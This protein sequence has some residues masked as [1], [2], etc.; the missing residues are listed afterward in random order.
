MAYTIY[1]KG[2]SL[3]KANSAPGR[4]NILYLGHISG[5]AVHDAVFSGISR[6]A[7]MRGWTAESV[8]YRVAHGK[9]LSVIL[10]EKRPV[11]CIVECSNGPPDLPPAAF[12]RVPAVFMNC[13]SVP[14]GRRIA[15][16]AVDN[17]SVAAAA[18]RELSSGNP[19]GF[20]AVGLSDSAM[21][22]G[23]WSNARV[24]AFRA[25][26]R[27]ERRRCLCLVDWGRGGDE[28]DA[29]LREWIAEL[30]PRTAV[31]AVNDATA[32]SIARAAKAAGRSI[33]R[34]LTLVGVDNDSALCETVSPSLSSIPMDF[35]SGGFLAARLLGEMM[36]AKKAAEQSLATKDTKKEKDI[37]NS[38]PFVAKNSTVTIS[39]G[40]LLVIRR[41]STGGRG[42]RE[43]WVLDAVEAIRREACDGLT[44]AAL[45]KRFRCSRWLL[46]KRFRE[47][48]GHSILDEIQHV[49]FQQVEALLSGTDTAIDAIAGM[50]G[51]GSEIELRH[52]FRRRTGMSMREWR[53]RRRR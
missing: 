11:G 14:R 48:T 9:G 12:G 45:A 47:A 19:D 6:Y 30:P 40:P 17:G 16:V 4:L 43:P 7:A 44:A 36:G 52:L 2:V 41:R 10:A 33:P 15:R 34:D 37:G 5:I 20:A 42:R 35:E 24:A 22:D 39:Y 21:P 29:R 50:C 46:E 28:P 8:N 1:M 23:I 49:R 31:F 25:L 26:C 27:K 32:A 38:V 51:F 13:L 53:K 18:F 3:N